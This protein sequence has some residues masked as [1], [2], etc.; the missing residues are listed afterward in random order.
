MRA[1]F[2]RQRDFQEELTGLKLPIDSPYDFRDHLCLMAEEF[3]ELAKVDKRWRN[4]D[5]SGKL[6]EGNK[7]DELA[8]VFI[9]AINLALF[10]E[11]TYDD[12]MRAIYKKIAR[13]E[14]RLKD[15]GRKTNI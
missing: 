7:I 11:F 3:G 15:V 14:R 13:N 2:D 5:G 12:L 6:P 10:S 8:D 1:V 9:V 4:F